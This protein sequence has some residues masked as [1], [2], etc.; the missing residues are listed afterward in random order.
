VNRLDGFDGRGLTH[1]HLGLLVLGNRDGDDD[2]DDRD[3]NQQLDE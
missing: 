1:E 2:Q 3:D